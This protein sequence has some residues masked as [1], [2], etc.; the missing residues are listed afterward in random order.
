MFISE[1]NKY[2]WESV[3]K[4]IYSATEKDIKRV[5]SKNKIEIKDFFALLSPKAEK[6]LALLANLSNKIT[7]ERFGKTVL[8]YAPL[9]LS[10]ECNNICTYC[11]FSL[12]NKI[13]RKTLSE[14]EII[15][16]CKALKKLGIKHVLVVT[17]ESNFNVGM[18]YFKMALNVIKNYFESISFEVQPLK[19]SEY[20]ELK[21]L[22]VNSI[23]IYQETYNKGCYKENHPKGKKSNFNFRLNTP[24]RI[25]KSNFYRI[26]IGALYG[27]E[28]WRVES[29]FVALHLKYLEK[30][31]W[32]TKY[33]ISF[34][35]L[36]P[37]EG[38]FMP[39]STMT[40]KQLVQIICA[41]RLISNEVEISISTRET[42]N[43][44]NNIFKVG[45]TTM[46]AGSK[47]NPGG[48]NSEKKSLEQ[49]EIS[50]E[51]LPKKFASHV[52]KE[53][54]DIVWKDWSSVIK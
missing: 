27:L 26:G 7:T 31:Y 40:D 5:L 12:E 2:S 50:D 54:Y 16:E 20:N 39:K 45:A 23:Y 42:E 38:N 49:F 29:F 15:A 53:G 6:Y 41:F 10:N 17:G 37:F 8:L 21:N 9:Y 32:K 33:S 35:R 13:A 14:K 47:T 43:F 24:D 28:D 18:S 44:R 30:K 22:G 1:F 3:K 11:G 51:R 34:P 46:S 52:I 25:A 4:N 48:Y 19:N 36:R